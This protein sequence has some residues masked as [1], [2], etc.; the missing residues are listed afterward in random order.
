M[1]LVLC[2][3]WHNCFTVVGAV[4]KLWTWTTALPDY[5]IE[6]CA[7]HSSSL[8]LDPFLSVGLSVCWLTGPCTGW[9]ALWCGGKYLCGLYRA[10]WSC[11][12][13]AANYVL[14]LGSRFVALWLPSLLLLLLLFHGCYTLW[15]VRIGIYLLLQEIPSF[16]S[17]SCR[18][19]VKF[20]TIKY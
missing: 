20:K 11:A 5:Y 3:G 8:T 9:P 19:G 12:I 13:V 17:S 1:L 4:Q 10:L 7:G 14:H 16:Q 18:D 2:G 15:L 6:R